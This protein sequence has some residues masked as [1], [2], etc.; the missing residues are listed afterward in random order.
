MNQINN[1]RGGVVVMVQ[2]IASRGHGPEPYSG[3]VIEI[4]PYDAGSTKQSTR[5]RLDT[6]NEFGK[7][8]QK[9]MSIK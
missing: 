9:Q 2:A 5:N 1:D 6:P 8:K 4:L 3:S 7:L